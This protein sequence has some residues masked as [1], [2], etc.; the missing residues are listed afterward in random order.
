MENDEYTIDDEI[1]DEV[2]WA[3]CYFS[4]SDIETIYFRDC[5]EEFYLGKAVSKI[6]PRKASY[7]KANLLRGCSGSN[8]VLLTALARV[9]SVRFRDYVELYLPDSLHETV[10][11]SDVDKMDDAPDFIDIAYEVS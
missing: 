4:L 2:R 6:R 10:Y 3:K 1:N 7:L 8:I 11:P 9:Y 5:F